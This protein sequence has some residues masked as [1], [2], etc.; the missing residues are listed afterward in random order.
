MQSTV[1]AENT[2]IKKLIMPA[3]KS[4]QSKREWTLITMWHFESHFK[5]FLEKV[6]PVFSLRKLWEL[7][8][9]KLGEGKDGK[10]MFHAERTALAK[11]L[12][13]RQKGTSVLYDSVC[14]T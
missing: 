4:S 12:S 9:N 2:K 3:L 5:D 14:S 1:G 10:R 7:A 6:T 11:V 13:K 8:F